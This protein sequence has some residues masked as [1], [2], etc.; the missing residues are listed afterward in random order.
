MGHTS[1]IPLI[2][3]VGPT[4]SGKTALSLALAER[5]NGEII[6]ADSRT[7]YTGMDIGTAKPTVQ[8]QQQVRHHLLDEVRPDQLFTV[9]D[10]Q[11]LAKA[12]IADIARRGKLPILVGGSGLYINSVLYDYDFRP[13]NSAVRAEFANASVEELQGELAARGIPLPENSRN[14]RYLL[15]SLEAGQAS[16]VHQE[17]RPHTLVLGLSVEPDVLAGRIEQRIAQMLENGLLDEVSSLSAQYS[18]DLPAMQAPAYK[19]FLP[20]LAGQCSLQQAQQDFATYDRQLAKKQRT[21]FK[22]NNSIHWLTDP[23]QAAQLV[24]KFLNTPSS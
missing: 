20:H 3:I 1:V 12:A 6:C 4:A 24:A 2:V 16:D 22:R 11:R 5:Y 14:K 19:A 8:E 23:S 13:V 9:A 18:A 7:V 15:R 21:W 10:F 17:L